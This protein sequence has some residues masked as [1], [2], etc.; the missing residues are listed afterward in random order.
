MKKE[1]GSHQQQEENN[2]LSFFINKTPA[3][4][5]SVHD[6]SDL[7]WF[8][9]YL[10]GKHGTAPHCICNELDRFFLLPLFCHLQVKRTD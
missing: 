5:A 10:T 7:E 2:I 6:L 1:A 8:T 9:P 3:Q 4:A